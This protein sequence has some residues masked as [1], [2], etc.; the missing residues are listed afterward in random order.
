MCDG[1]KSL[2]VSALQGESFLLIGVWQG[3]KDDST[4]QANKKKPNGSVS[5]IFKVGFQSFNHE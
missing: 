5:L 1:L 2:I 4:T 3:F